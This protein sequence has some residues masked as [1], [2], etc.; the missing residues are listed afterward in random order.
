MTK[1]FSHIPVLLKEV[2]EN[3]NLR[4]GMTCLDGTVGGAGHS[5]EIIKRIGNA[6][7]LFCIDRDPEAV[8]TASN[9]LSEYKNVTVMEGNFRDVSILL[10]D[11][12]GKI[13]SAL[14]DLG[15]SSHQLDTSE[16]GFSYHGDAALDMRMSDKGM[17][18]A[19]I[20]NEA[21]EEY[22]ADILRKFGEEKFARLIA[23]KIVSAREGE[24]IETTGRLAEIVISS[25]PPS[26][27][28]KGGNPAQKTFMALRIAVN[29]ELDSLE[30]G[31]ND[32]FE[33]LSPK[34]RLT[35]ITFHSLEDRIVKN[36]YKSLATGCTCPPDFPVCVCGKEP[37]GKIVN[38]KP[39][40]ASTDEM[41]NNRRS[42][43]AKLR[44]IE[45]VVK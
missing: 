38:K 14:L 5:S 13:D 44:T 4:E 40:T 6:G 9:R 2:I 36:F 34:G 20:V 1:E 26:V 22:L 33:Y 45:K 12:K 43:S 7:R 29:D 18:A 32:I 28:R 17:T 21:D 27:R 41:E 23:K 8:K 16:R 24:K 10:P 39:I 31:L 15:V 19:E 42:R 30:E 35:V 11:E 25:L 37:R 3:M